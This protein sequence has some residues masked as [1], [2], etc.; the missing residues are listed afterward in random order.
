MGINKICSHIQQGYLD[1][2]H[3][4]G[5]FLLWY[6][7]NILNCSFHIYKCVTEQSYGKKRHHSHPEMINKLWQYLKKNRLIFKTDNPLSM[8]LDSS[9]LVSFPLISSLFSHWFIYSF[10]YLVIVELLSDTNALIQRKT[11]KISQKTDSRTENRAKLVKT[12]EWKENEKQRTMFVLMQNGP[13][14]GCVRS[15]ACRQSECVFGWMCACMGFCWRCCVVIRQKGRVC[16]CADSVS[17][18]WTSTRLLTRCR[19]TCP[20]RPVWHLNDNAEL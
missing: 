5:D 15:T 14:L 13:V 8:H 19:N 12:R 9:K 11:L 1:L 3:F 4:G 16:P 10:I 6:L 17:A 7:I 20:R 2:C 18:C